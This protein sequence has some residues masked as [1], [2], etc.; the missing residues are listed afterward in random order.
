MC[1]PSPLL[2][3]TP[4]A[5]LFFLRVFFPEISTHCISLPLSLLFRHS[6]FRQHKTKDKHEID[7]MTLTMVRQVYTLQST[8]HCDKGA[9]NIRCTYYKQALYTCWKAHRQYESLLNPEH[10][11]LACVYLT[12]IPKAHRCLYPMHTELYVNRQLMHAS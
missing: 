3:S 6:P 11:G 8:L 4:F 9:H 5:C 7:R 10:M 1:P 12:V 2:I